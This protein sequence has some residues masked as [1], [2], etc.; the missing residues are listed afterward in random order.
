MLPSLP[1]PPAHVI[2]VI[3]ENKDYDDIIG[4]QKNAPYINSLATRAAVFT[5]SHG[6]AHPSQPNYMAI[7]SGLKNTD[8][9]DCDIDGIPASAPNLGGET[10]KA[11][12]TFVGYAEDLPA[13]GSTVCYNGEYARKHVPWVHFSD[14]PAKDNQPFSAFPAYEKLPTISFVIPNLVNDMHSASIARGDAWL[15]AHLSSLMNWAMQHNTLVVLTWDE[16]DGGF[17]NHIPTLF[18]GPMVKPGRYAQRITHY[19]VL[20]T[21]EDFYRLPPAGASAQAAPIDGIW[22]P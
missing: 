2:V 20:R 10:L 15:R 19:D 1:P 8:G 5:N 12:L 22:R 9:D 18:V 7:F 13:P 17:T 4:N 21:I 14:I 16:D 11:K 6:V 3:E